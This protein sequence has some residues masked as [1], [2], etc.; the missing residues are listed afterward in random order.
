MGTGSKEPR[1]PSEALGKL[2]PLVKAG[3][4]VQHTR[5]YHELKL[6]GIHQSELIYVIRLPPLWLLLTKTPPRV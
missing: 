2:S 3:S 5:L 6:E 1:S 4:S